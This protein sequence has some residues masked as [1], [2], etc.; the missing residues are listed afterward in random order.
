M[1]AGS[2]AFLL[3]FMGLLL[4]LPLAEH[5]AVHSACLGLVLA[6]AP[7]ACAAPV[8]LPEACAGWQS[9]HWAPAAGVHRTGGSRRPASAFT[10]STNDQ[11][12]PLPRSQ[13]HLQLFDNQVAE[14]RVAAVHQAL[15]G[16]LLVVPPAWPPGGRAVQCRAAL[17][18]LCLFA[19]WLVPTYAVL[20][21]HCQER[22]QEAAAAAEAAAARARAGGGG[23]AAA[24]AAAPAVAKPS[25]SEWVA[26][27]VFMHGA[28]VEFRCHAWT[29]LAL[30]CWLAGSA[31]AA[32][33]QPADGLS[34]E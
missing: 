34:Q 29:A 28:P 4:P 11:N 21:W 18:A 24:A 19:G 27:N 22:A 14:Q 3:L 20:R 15:G 12:S 5:L 9:L 33:R 26:E 1:P 30:G 32:G 23:A 25:W 13:T 17:S 10:G 7:R 16:L 6:H 8:R 2:Q 31:W